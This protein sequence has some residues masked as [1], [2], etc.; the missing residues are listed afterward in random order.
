MPHPQPHV[1][2]SQRVRAWSLEVDEVLR[3]LGSTRGGLDASEAHERRLRDGPNR[4]REHKSRSLVAIL[5]AQLQSVLV[6]LL[7]LAVVA[8]FA[9]GRIVEGVAVALVIVLDTVIGFA[10]EARATRSMEALRQLGQ[11]TATVRRSGEHLRVPA[12]ELAIGDLV[13]VEAGDIVA[14]DLRIVEAS[15][16]QVDESLLTGESLPVE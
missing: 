7:A 10:M 2:E 3:L 5:V 8:S 6:V 12:S 16:L 15:K 4:L 13:I 14:A 1:Q 11:V 9:M